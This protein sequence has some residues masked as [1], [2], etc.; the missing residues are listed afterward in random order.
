M[1]ELA[2]G[3]ALRTWRPDRAALGRFSAATS[4]AQHRAIYRRIVEG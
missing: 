2:G 3:N 1:I 4:A